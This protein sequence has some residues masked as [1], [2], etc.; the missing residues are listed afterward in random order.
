MAPDRSS[1]K[2]LA[3]MAILLVEDVWH[4]ADAQAFALEAAGAKVVG[5]AATLAAAERMAETMTFDA[6]VM[7]LNLHGEFT[8]DL[9][10]RLG[11]N[12]VKVVVISGYTATPELTAKAHAC[13]GK[14]ASSDAI[15][16]A[17]RTPLRD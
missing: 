10:I 15:I 3:G 4:L 13:L 16:A 12:G 14:P 6:A 8:H 5:V 7:D 1:P 17:L 2:P 11:A 9:L